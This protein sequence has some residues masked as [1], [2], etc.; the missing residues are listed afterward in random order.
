MQ[1]LSPMSDYPSWE[2]LRAANELVVDMS[3][4]GESADDLIE[5]IHF[6]TEGWQEWIPWTKDRIRRIWNG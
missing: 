6:Y 4:M 5:R 2:T 1:K 3:L